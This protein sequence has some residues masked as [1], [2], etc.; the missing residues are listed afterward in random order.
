MSSGTRSRSNSRVT[1]NKIKLYVLD[2]ESM[3]T[4]QMIVQTQVQMTLMVMD[5]I[6]Q[7][8]N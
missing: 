2:A 3:I 5:P 7:H 4:L 1:T 8:C 6:V